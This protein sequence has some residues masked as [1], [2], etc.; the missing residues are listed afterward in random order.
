MTSDDYGRIMHELSA[1]FPGNKY[2]GSD[3]AKR[4]YAAKFM[5][6]DRDALAR[7]SA[8]II[9][10]R[11]HFP[12]VAILLRYVRAAQAG[13]DSE[14][15]APM[16]RFA[17]TDAHR[18]EFARDRAETARING[19]ADAE[20]SLDIA[21]QHARGVLCDEC[22]MPQYTMRNWMSEEPFPVQPPHRCPVCY[23]TGWN[24]RMLDGSSP[25]PAIS[26]RALREVVERM[27]S[28][29]VA[30]PPEDLF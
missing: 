27:A 17:T 19:R 14:R 11:E 25:V 29:V 24:P 13:L 6:G 20:K 28:Q 12:S 7:A 3:P 2:A 15:S 30:P 23:G 22:M 9:E 1:A 21:L 4:A 16:L 10:E 26:V 18:R 8:T 5:H